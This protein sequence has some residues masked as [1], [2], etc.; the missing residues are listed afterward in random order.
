MKLKLTA[1]YKH[2]ITIIIT[3]HKHFRDCWRF[4]RT[5]ILEILALHSP[6]ARHV[7]EIFHIFSVFTY[8]LVPILNVSLVEP[9]PTS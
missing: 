6:L 4:W 2:D 7:G 9:K 1:L 8:F 5:L 3:V